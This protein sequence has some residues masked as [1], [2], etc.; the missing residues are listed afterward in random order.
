MRATV[1]LMSV[2]LLGCAV[3]TQPPDSAELEAIVAADQKDREPEMA[4]IDWMAVS[5]RDADRRKRVLEMIEA[6]QVVTGKDFWRA[7]LVF[8][9]GEG[10]NDILVAH[11]L[12]V[13]SLG[14]GQPEARRMA[15]ITLD[16]YLNRIG[17]PQVFGTQFSSQRP[18][19]SASW[20]ME[21]YDT[22]LIGDG[23]RGLNCV[24]PLAKQLQILED[25]RQGK[26]PAGDEVCK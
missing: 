8:Q 17:Q 18:E 6:K 24:E 22:K 11:I 10:S 2:I 21:P 7:A 19:D 13:I 9:H 20:R 25:L 16:R 14:K 3:P 1:A 26:E 15:A 23:L 12:A 5:G 4:K